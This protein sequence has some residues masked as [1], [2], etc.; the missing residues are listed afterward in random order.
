MKMAKFILVECKILRKSSNSKKIGE[1]FP[2]VSE[3]WP[4]KND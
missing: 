3:K 1:N 2:K 4:P